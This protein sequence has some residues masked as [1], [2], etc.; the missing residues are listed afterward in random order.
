MATKLHNAAVIINLKRVTINDLHEGEYCKC[1][2]EGENRLMIKF[3]GGMLDVC[4]GQVFGWTP[5]FGAIECSYI[6]PGSE[7][8]ILVGCNMVEDHTDVQKH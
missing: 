4:S 8:T 3:S 7:L 2:V 5:Q 1:V 6:P